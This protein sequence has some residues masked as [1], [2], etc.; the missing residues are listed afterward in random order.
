VQALG[1]FVSPDIDA[2]HRA[3]EVYRHL[4]KR[5]VEQRSSRSEVRSVDSVP[6]K[7]R[8]EARGVNKNLRGAKSALDSFLRTELSKIRLKGK[9]L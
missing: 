9:V 2:F 6:E 7:V 3:G 1:F 4:N 5:R 8:E